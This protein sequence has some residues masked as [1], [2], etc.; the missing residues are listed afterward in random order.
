MQ[1]PG[2]F[3][4]PLPS[5]KLILVCVWREEWRASS[6]SGQSRGHGGERTL[7]L[8]LYQRPQKAPWLLPHVG[9]QREVADCHTEGFPMHSTPRALCLGLPASKTVRS[10][11]LWLSP[12]S[13][14]HNVLL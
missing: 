9:T 6:Q 7:D 12:T 10:E 3:P 8:P 4:G 11:F 5:G 14:V 2:R 13:P 1:S